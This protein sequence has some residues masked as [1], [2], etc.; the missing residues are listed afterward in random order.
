VVTAHRVPLRGLEAVSL[1][2]YLGALGVLRAVAGQIDAEAVLGWDHGVPVLESSLDAEQLVDWLTDG[3]VPS[4][5]ISPWNAGS[6]FA[7]N[8]KSKEAEKA[9]AAVAASDLARLAPLREAIT[10]G[11]AV[12]AEGR[13]RGWAGGTMWDAKHK[14]SLLT[15]CRNRLPDEV[16][17]WLD[18][19]LALDGEGVFY[20]P[21]AGSGGNFG[22]QDLSASYIQQLLQ[23]MGPGA[24]RQTSADWAR[25]VIT[26]QDHAPY[27]RGTVGQFD[28]GRSGGIHS[29]VFEKLDDKGFINAWRTVL[30]CEGL[31]LFASSATRRNAAGP[32]QSSPFVV[33]S[34]PYGYGSAS[35]AETVKGELWAPLWRAPARL[36]ELE[37]LLGEGRAQY[38]GRQARS[39]FDFARAAG[40][41]GVDRSLSAFRRFVIVERLGQNPLA[42][43]AGDVPVDGSAEEGRLRQAA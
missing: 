28:P 8:G 5:L 43:R 7:G 19:A 26:G 31:L 37:Q 24:R 10:A 2:D 23:L 11:H 33:R 6:G 39:G 41:F 34:T 12:V 18:T 17:P 38:R 42:I 36:P 15:L 29:T 14:T 25:S 4:P 27:A 13:A 20:N 32:A 3:F 21:L 22:R 35:A 30:T 9:L 16:L 40:S 1:A